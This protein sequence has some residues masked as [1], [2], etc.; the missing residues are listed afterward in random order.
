MA[1]S[2]S[3]NSFTKTIIRP[4]SIDGYVPKNKKLLTKDYTYLI[5]SNNNGTSEIFNYENFNSS[6]CNFLAYGM[7][8]YGGEIALVPTNYGNA[9]GMFYD[10]H[11]IAGGKYPPADYIKDNF[12]IWLQKNSVNLEWGIAGGII[13]TGLG[14]GRMFAGDY[15]GFSNV[16]GGI[17]NLINIMKEVYIQSKVPPTSA[18]STNIGTLNV[19]QKSNGFSFTQMCI[20]KEYAK[21][22]DD[23]FSM[24]GYK[25]TEIK[26]PNI[27][28]RLNWNYVKTNNA[29]VESSEVPEIYLNE[30]KEMLNNGITFWHNPQTFLDYSQTNS[31]V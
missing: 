28:G 29:V 16:G 18:S 2:S 5:V 31:I 19:A 23:F 24:Y 27:T 9:S 8:S 15:S 7:A 10:I 21:I 25:V 3:V 26:V 1:S 20:K 6:N 4:S 22:I 12:R 17:G 13:E 11:K 14:A 30:F